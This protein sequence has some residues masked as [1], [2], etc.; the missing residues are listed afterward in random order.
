MEGLMAILHKYGYDG[1][2]SSELVSPY[3]RD[4]ELFA[5]QEIRNIRRVLAGR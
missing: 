5:A 2:L 3:G 1:W 4:P